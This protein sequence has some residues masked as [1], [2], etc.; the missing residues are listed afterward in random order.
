MYV[1]RLILM[2]VP[3]VAITAILFGTVFLFAVITDTY[4]VV[5]S[6]G[7]S[8]AGKVQVLAEAILTGAALG[9]AIGIILFL[10]LL[11]WDAAKNLGPL[12]RRLW[13]W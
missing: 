9:L 6:E 8:L 10:L 12:A 5:P 4:P 11:G 13:R 1:R 7:F 3:T 2:C